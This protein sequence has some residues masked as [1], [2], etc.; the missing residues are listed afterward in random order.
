MLKVGWL[1]QFLIIRWQWS[2]LNGSTLPFMKDFSVAYNAVWQH[3]THNRTSFCWSQ[4]S[5]TLLLLLYQLSLY[6]SFHKFFNWTRFIRGITMA[7]TALQNVLLKKLRLEDQNFFLIYDFQNECC[8]SC[9][10]ITLITL[11]N[12]IRTLG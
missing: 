11:H 5:Q 2:L 12:S 3:F 8:V 7:A 10:K 1:Y 4:F 9:M 6:N